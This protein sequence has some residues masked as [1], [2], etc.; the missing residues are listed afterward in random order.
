LKLIYAIVLAANSCLYGV[1]ANFYVSSDIS[2]QKLF[3][4]FCVSAVPF[5]LNFHV[6]S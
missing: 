1:L 5:A 3:L 6:A 2:V 4:A